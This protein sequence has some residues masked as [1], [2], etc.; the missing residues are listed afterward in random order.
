MA[1]KARWAGLQLER[2]DLLLF[3]AVV[4]VAALV[5]LFQLGSPAQ[6][7]FDE[8]YY[9][10]DACVYLGRGLADCGIA[11]EASWVHPPLGKWLISLGILVFGYDPV[12]WRATAA[13]AGIL[14]VGFLYLLA[15][16]LTGSSLAATIAAGIVALDPLSIV[17]SRVAML[18]VFVTC[19]SVGALF[20]VVLD[21]DALAAS[22]TSSRRLL[23]PWR[24]AAGIAG[25]VAVAT[26]WSGALLLIAIILLVLVWEAAAARRRGDAIGAALRRAAPSVLLWLVVLPTAIYVASYV[27]R[28]PGTLLTLPWASDSWLRFFGHRQLAMLRFHIGLMDTDSYASPAWS[29]PLG[30][31]AIVYYFQADAS[32]QYREI[33]AFADPLLWVAGLLAALWAAALALWRRAV[34]GPELVVAAGTAAPYVPWLLLNADRSFVFMY[35][36]LPTV[37]FVALALGWAVT[38]LPRVPA[39]AL[40]TAVAAVAI[41]VAVFWSPLIYGW[42]LDYPSWRMRMIF[43]DCTSA[44]QTAGRLAPAVQQGPPPPGWCWV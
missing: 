14:T 11:S 33:L 35:Y 24:I 44:Q 5:R 38:R 25:G 26:K 2:R 1:P 37:P 8:N 15:R 10:Q 23:R 19:A 34:W 27:G 32:G 39:R 12:G 20:F 28:L 7:V 21:R 4:G 36:F 43:A 3:L 29:W 31:R 6:L 18:D 42:P 9:A 22:P 30:K 16:R 17:S 40:A 13:L 41:G